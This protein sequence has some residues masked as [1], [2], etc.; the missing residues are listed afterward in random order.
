MKSRMSVPK[1][2]GAGAFSVGPGVPVP[3]TVTF[4]GGA[5]R[6]GAGVPGA[7]DACGE[8]G[9]SGA[10]GNSAADGGS[11]FVACLTCGGEQQAGGGAELAGAAGDGGDVL[12]RQGVDLFGGAVQGAREH[13]HR[14]E[15]GH[16]RVHGDGFRACGGGAHQG[17][18]GALGAG[19]THGL[20]GR[21]RHE[22]LADAAARAVDEGE[23]AR[24]QAEV[25]DGLGDGLAHEFA[26]AGV[27][28]VRL[29]DHGAAGGEGRGGV[30]ARRREGQREVAGAE[31]GDGTQRDLALADV[32][33]GQGGA[34]RQGRID[35]HAAEVALADHVGEEPQLSGGAGAFALQPGGGQAGLLAGADDQFVADG[36]DVV[37]NRVQER[38]VGFGIK[39]AEGLEGLGGRGRWRP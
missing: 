6:L 28:V 9:L 18:A 26:G 27:G 1:M 30:A 37:R 39:G 34:V 13:E 21:V 23:D 14:V 17:D 20:D 32:G 22:G 5:E 4:C 19:E 38:G 12:L 35:A 36:F 25:L 24:V 33:A 15:G 8:H 31:D 7:G 11:Q 16:L 2:A 3:T 29:E 10:G